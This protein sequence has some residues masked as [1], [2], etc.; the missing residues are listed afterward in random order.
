MRR[1]RQP[2]EPSA[3]EMQVHWDAGCEPYRAWC[4]YCV[5]GRG[6]ADRHS[7]H[8]HTQDGLAAIGIDYGYLGAELE[9]TPLLCGKDQ[10]HRWFY[11]L[12]LP[13]K[14]VGDWS[15]KALAEQLRLAGHCRM[16]IRCYSEPAM[17][18]F[19]NWCF[20]DL[21]GEVRPRGCA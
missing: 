17:L 15:C 10:K 7:V 8:D 18:S 14:G 9:A 6:R 12:P 16:V 4:P 19:S 13:A 5:A 2:H 20:K 11:G 1:Q 3:E 21:A